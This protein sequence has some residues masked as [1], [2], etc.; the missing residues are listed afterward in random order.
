[1]ADRRMRE[2]SCDG[3]ALAS[4]PNRR[5]RLFAITKVTVLRLTSS[6]VICAVA[7]MEYVLYGE[8]T[9]GQMHREVDWRP[10]SYST[11]QLR[12]EELGVCTQ[13]KVGSWSAN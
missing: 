2:W 11:C 8:D 5:S 3:S 9:I 4:C 10:Q 7:Y 12:K 1:M 13:C 6:L